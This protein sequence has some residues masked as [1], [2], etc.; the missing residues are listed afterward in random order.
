MTDRFLSRLQAALDHRSVMAAF[1]EAISTTPR[2][3]WDVLFRVDHGTTLVQSNIRPEWD[4]LFERGVEVKRFTVPRPDVGT[5]WAFRVTINPIKRN[6]A[7]VTI[8]ASEWLAARQ[9]RL[10]AEFVGTQFQRGYVQERSHG[11]RVALSLVTVSGHLTVTDSDL[12]HLS[13]LH[14]IGRGK[15]FGAGLLSIAPL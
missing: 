12:F 11:N 8:P 13:L 14:G 7:A 4:R 15:A 2:Q 5:R 10:G 1:P 6:P 9:E 3:D